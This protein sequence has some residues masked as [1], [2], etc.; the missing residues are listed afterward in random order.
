MKP[1]VAAF[2]AALLAG[3]AAFAACNGMAEKATPQTTAELPVLPP[4]QPGS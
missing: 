3:G 2:A 4:E 1:L